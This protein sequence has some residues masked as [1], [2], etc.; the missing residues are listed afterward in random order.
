MFI[1]DKISL[2]KMIRFATV[3]NLGLVDAKVLAEKMVEMGLDNIDRPESIQKILRITKS[4]NDG[5][6]CF[7]DVHELI[8]GK[9]DTVSLEDLQ[10]LSL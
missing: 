7:N 6:I 5:K 4:V 9:P 3:P 2:I 8:W 10:K 1:M